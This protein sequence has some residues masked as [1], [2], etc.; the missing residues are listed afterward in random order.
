MGWTL[1]H[2]TEQET[3]DKIVNTQVTGYLPML[4]GSE[5]GAIWGSSTYFARDAQY[6]HTYTER[7]NE[8]KMLLYRVIEGEWVKG[9]PEIKEFLLVE[10]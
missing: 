6:S 1:F 10:P 9:A 5:V 2:D 8:R 3:I 4:S 7:K